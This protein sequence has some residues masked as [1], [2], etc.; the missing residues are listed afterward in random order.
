MLYIRFFNLI[1]LIAESLYL[2]TRFLRACDT[3]VD[4]T[5]FWEK[6]LSRIKQ[7]YRQQH[8]DSDV[9]ISASPEFLLKPLEKLLHITVIASRVSP[10]DGK[11]TGSNC[12]HQE[13]VTRFFEKFPDG[14]IDR[15]YSDS[16]S[17]EPLASIAKEAYIV[18]EDRILPWDPEQHK[19]HLRT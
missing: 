2:F 12:Y 14:K 1:H 17:D 9:I 10:A 4:V 5:A 11:T 18:K 15:F 19:K 3:E 13:K 16:Y 6:N 8:Q 7:F